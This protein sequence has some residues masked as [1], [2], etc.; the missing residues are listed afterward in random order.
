MVRTIRRLDRSR[1]F[2][3]ILPRTGRVAYFQD[4]LSFDYQGY[5]VEDGEPPTEQELKRL[6]GDKG[7][8]K[9]ASSV[10]GPGDPPPPPPPGDP[11]AVALIPRPTMEWQTMKFPE[12]RAL[13]LKEKGY[14]APNQV[15]ALRYLDSQ[16]LIVKD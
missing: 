12:L 9:G 11:A 7:A 14:K 5:C 8:P 13:L 3:H 4:H 1:P 2:G 10:S 16:N 6:A 15:A